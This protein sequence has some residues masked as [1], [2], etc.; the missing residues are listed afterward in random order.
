MVVKTH[1][2]IKLSSICTET[3]AKLALVVNFKQNMDNTKLSC[4]K[5]SAR[6]GCTSLQPKSIIYNLQSKCSIQL[7]VI[8]FAY[9]SIK[10]TYVLL[11]YQY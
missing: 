4:R 6:C 8:K 3:Y 2:V 11:V 9:A 10:F 5:D 7:R 1:V